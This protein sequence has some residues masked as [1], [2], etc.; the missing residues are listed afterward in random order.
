MFHVTTTFRSYPFDT[1]EEACAF[2]LIVDPT[3]DRG[4]RIECFRVVTPFRA[5]VFATYTEARSFQL[6]VD[7]AGDLGY[8]IE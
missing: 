3:G 8:R 6:A 2:L 4:Y 7:P 1:Y 5:Y